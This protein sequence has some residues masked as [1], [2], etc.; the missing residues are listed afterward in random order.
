MQTRFG[1]DWDSLLADEFE[2]DYMKH[3]QVFLTKEYQ[4]HVIFPP[5]EEV[6]N[7]LRFTPYGQVKVVILG[8]DPYPGRG[9]AHGLSFSVREGI[10]LPKSLQN[11]FTE[12]HDDIGFQIPRSGCLEKWAKQG[13]LLLNT[14]LTV[15]EGEP[16]SHKNK[17]WELFT[18]RVI[19]LLNEREKPVIFV[20]WGANAKAK[21][22]FITNSRHYVLTAQHPSPLSAFRGFFGCRHFSK[23]NL[24]LERNQMEP[25]DWQL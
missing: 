25:I 23:I 15:R 2:K 6:L 22:P 1:N 12:L 7:A 4:E 5:K 20:F 19:T 8:Q 21:L 10:P 18:D 9:Q 16:N 11:I 24:I 13:V 17:G 14:V 3:L